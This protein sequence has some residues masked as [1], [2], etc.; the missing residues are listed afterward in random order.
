[1][2]IPQESPLGCVQTKAA[3]FEQAALVGTHDDRAPSVLVSELS[4][5]CQ[6]TGRTS[7]AGSVTSLRV[8]GNSNPR[9]IR[10]GLS[11]A[12]KPAQQPSATRE[13][14]IMTAKAI[15]TLS[16]TIIGLLCITP[17]L[18]TIGCAND[19]G[20]PTSP[21]SVGV[22]TGIGANGAADPTVTTTAKAE[23]S[24]L[25]LTKTCGG[26]DHCTVET[27]EAGPLPSGTDIFYTGP[28]L[29]HR[30]TS[31]IVVTTPS[32]DSAF[33][34]CS[35]SYRS[36]T[37]TCVLTGGTGALSG[38]HAN[39]KVTTDFSDPRYPAGLFTW[40]GTYHFAPVKVN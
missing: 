29:E 23:P 30:T 13:G 2:A 37:G 22:R 4:A 1:M 7:A 15:T 33:G 18:S 8:S 36:F 25:L 17:L 34:H 11:F 12:A 28:S 39:V 19:A 14:V 20:L 26:A 10:S 6:P 5:F 32:G 3:E 16:R 31:G 24:T 21:T 35:L 27:S 38:V 40:E 9:T